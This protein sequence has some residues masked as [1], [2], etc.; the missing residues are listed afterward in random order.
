MVKSKNSLAN[1]LL[2]NKEYILLIVIVFLTL[3]TIFK[4]LGISFKD[5]RDPT[6]HLKKKLVVETLDNPKKS[7]HKRFREHIKEKKQGKK[8]NDNYKQ[9]NE[10]NL[11]IEHPEERHEHCSKFTEES[12]CKRHCHCGWAH[13]Y[14]HKHDGLHGH[15]EAHDITTKTHCDRPNYVSLDHKICHYERG[16]HCDKKESCFNDKNACEKFI[17]DHGMEYDESEKYHITDKRHPKAYENKNKEESSAKELT[18]DGD[19]TE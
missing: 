13:S 15:C 8:T 9:K 10:Y 3:L 14:S 17:K 18:A 2:E 6:L 7:E 5:A 16:D 19:E 11:N 4:M 12:E 1:F